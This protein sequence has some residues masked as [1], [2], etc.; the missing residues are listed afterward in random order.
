MT[1][2]QM[3]R[4]HEPVHPNLHPINALRGQHPSQA[5]ASLLSNISQVGLGNNACSAR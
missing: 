3:G 4:V 5:T 2:A 1:G